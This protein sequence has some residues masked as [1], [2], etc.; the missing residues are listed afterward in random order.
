MCYVS[1]QRNDKEAQAKERSAKEWIQLAK[2][3]RDAGML[4]L[5]LTGGEVFLRKDFKQIYEELTNL[6]LVIQINTNATLITPEIASWLGKIPPSHVSVSIYGASSDTYAKICGDAS[7]YQRTIRGIELLLSEGIKL[8]IRTTVVRGNAKDF[9]ELTKLTETYGVTLS[10]VDYIYP[11]REGESFCPET[12]RLSPIELI[13]Y[14]KKTEEYYRKRLLERLDKQQSVDNGIDLPAILESEED[15]LHPFQCISGKCRFCI[16]WD[17][18]M[19][20][21]VLMSDPTAYPFAEGFINAWRE[22]VGLCSGIPECIECLQC[23]YK[24]ACM[25]CPASRRSETGHYNF[26]VPYLCELMECKLST[27]R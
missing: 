19:V 15:L 21:C 26:P 25:S 2:E 27:R 4:Y 24:G 9:L 16:T 5:M 20:P 12:E 22:L 8:K 1:R 17:G 23:A 18:R 6:G 3:A 14:E 11:R 13:N 10:I 7:G